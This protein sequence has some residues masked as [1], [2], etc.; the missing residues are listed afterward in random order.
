MTR[1]EAIRVLALMSLVFAAGL[2]ILAILNVRS[3]LVYAGPKWWPPLLAFA[4][5][6]GALG[7][8]MMYFK[9]WAVAAFAITTTSIGLWLLIGSTILGIKSDNLW[10]LAN[11]PFGLGLCLPMVTAIGCWRDLK[12]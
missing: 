7:L 2:S 12:W 9:K 4:V 6:W 11:V 3:W 8:R 10:V 1:L 5:Y